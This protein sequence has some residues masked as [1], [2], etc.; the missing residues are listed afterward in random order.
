M[1]EIERK[2]EEGEQEGVFMWEGEEEVG[3]GRG[4]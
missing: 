2:R 4:K 3:K 1:D